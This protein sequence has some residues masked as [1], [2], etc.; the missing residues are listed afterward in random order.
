VYSSFVC[1]F[2]LVV[3]KARL[4]YRSLL[5]TTN[6]KVALQVESTIYH[7]SFLIGHFRS[8][9]LSNKLRHHL[10]FGLVTYTIETC[11][12][13]GGALSKLMALNSIS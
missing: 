12:S 3:G 9:G 4:R 13:A 10:K 8:E 1:F 6:F 2:D 5:L 7:F 11:H